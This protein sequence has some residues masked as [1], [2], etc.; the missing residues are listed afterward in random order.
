MPQSSAVLYWFVCAAWRVALDVGVWLHTYI[1]GIDNLEGTHGFAHAA[2]VP[3]QKLVVQAADTA[4]SN[5][6]T[7]PGTSS[8][9]LMWSSATK[10]TLKGTFSL[11]W[12][13]ACNPAETPANAQLTAQ[14]AVPANALGTTSLP[15][16]TSSAHDAV[17]TESG[18]VIWAHGAYVAGVTGITGAFVNADAG[19]IAI[20]HGS[21]DY[22]FVHS[23]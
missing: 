4:C 18:A 23:R 2:I 8:P 17:V 16:L 21:G 22:A 1:G 3:P 14:V 13:V 9:P 6:T 20:Q 7:R 19:T 5:H 12:K 11:S 10:H 15:L